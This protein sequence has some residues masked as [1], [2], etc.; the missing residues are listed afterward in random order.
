L[1]Y[2]G[3]H[4]IPLHLLLGDHS[5]DEDPLPSVGHYHIW[6]D[7]VAETQHEE[8]GNS[9]RPEHVD[10]EQR[11]TPDLVLELQHAAENE[12][13]EDVINESEYIRAEE[14]KRN[15]APQFELSLCADVQFYLFETTADAV[16]THVDKVEEGAIA[17]VL[18]SHACIEQNVDYT[19]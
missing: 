15:E 3:R 8:V 1:L 2:L 17:I 9:H 18:N 7:V 11:A 12:S 16:V 19:E 13:N 6:R 5:P 10:Y 4:R 14:H